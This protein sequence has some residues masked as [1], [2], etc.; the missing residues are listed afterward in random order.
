MGHK[1]CFE[2]GRSLQFNLCGRLRAAPANGCLVPRRRGLHRQRVPEANRDGNALQHVGC[3][4]NLPPSAGGSVF[5]LQALIM[6]VMV[7]PRSERSWF[8]L[9]GST[10]SG[11]SRSGLKS[12]ELPTPGA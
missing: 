5:F 8:D 7:L 12:R 10:V 2:A 11:T 1:F 3:F 9:G 4:R 6:D